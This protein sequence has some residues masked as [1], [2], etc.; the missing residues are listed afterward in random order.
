MNL[1]LLGV[2]PDFYK[3]WCL[4]CLWFSSKMSSNLIN[5]FQDAFSYKSS[6]FIGFW[7]FKRVVMFEKLLN[8]TSEIEFL[9]EMKFYV[10]AWWLCDKFR[11]EWRLEE[12]TTHIYSPF[13]HTRMASSNVVFNLAPWSCRVSALTRWNRLLFSNSEECML[14]WT[15]KVMYDVEFNFSD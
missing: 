6:V 8:W 14:W 5:I 10:L 1:R 3:V 2:Y 11:D 9:L 12:T 7:L 13:K 15:L 4:G